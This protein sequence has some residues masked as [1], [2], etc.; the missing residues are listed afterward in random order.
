[1]RKLLEL[2]GITK[3]YPGVKA[4]NEIDLEINEGE[5]HA[6]M[7]ENGAG[8]STLIKVISGAIKPNKGTINFEGVQYTEM[9]PILS[10]KLGIGVIYQEF[11][12]VPELSIAENIFLGRRLTGGFTVNRRLMNK[13]AEEIMKSFGLDID[14]KQPVKT[15][16]VAYQQ[17][18]EIAKTISNDVKVLIMDEPSAPLTNREIEAMFSI[19]RQ[20]KEKGIAIIYISHR[21]EEIFEISDRITVMRDGEYVG[22]KPTKDTTK[23]ELIKMM[24]G[25]TLNEQFP[26]LERKTG[27]V[28]LEVKHLSTAGLLKDI[29]F[30]VR[31][32]EILGLAGLVGAGRTETARA[33]YGADPITHGEI[34]IN[35]KKVRIEKPENAIREGIAYIPEDRKRHGVLLEMSIKEN[36]SFIALRSISKATLV[37][38]AADKK[39]AKDYI[40][41]LRIKTPGMDQLSKN[42]SG[43]NQQ[44][45]VLAKSLAGKSNIIIFDEPTRG[46]DVG[47]KQEIYRLMQELAKEGMAII[48][49]SSEMPEL[50]GMSDRIIVMH[51]G[52]ITGELCREE[53]TQEAVLAFASGNRGKEDEKIE[54]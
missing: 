41:K 15:L 48:M 2:K 53:A 18:V 9:N 36:I 17:L 43:G 21:M 40:D 42:L 5:V 7:G 29:N 4:L 52:E 6:L 34:Y 25:R 33:V 11:N 10:Q 49:I 3:E 46:I 14:V 22:T 37:N 35:G 44:K 24:V 38:K 20:L 12:L 8:K 45:V 31:S 27:E 13:K 39:L 26:Q 50:L 23:Q 1:M 32:G 16:T 30:R 51:E 54:N 28:M 19:I 47:A